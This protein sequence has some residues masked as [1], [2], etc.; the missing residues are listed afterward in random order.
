MTQA[1]LREMGI[2]IVPDFASCT[3]LAS[4]HILR[5]QKFICAL[6][7]AP[8]VL[9]TDFVN[10]CLSQNKRLEPENY[11]LQDT[12]SEKRMGYKLSDSLARAKSNKG[13]LLR[14]Y[15]IYCTENIH[16]GFETYKS[17]VEVNGG[18]CL[19]YRARAGATATLRAGLHEENDG[20][21]AGTSG[22]VYLI[23][24]TTPGEAKLW[25]KFRQMIEGLG[26]NSLVVR[27]D[28]VL[29]LALSQKHQWLDFYNLT[30]KDVKFTA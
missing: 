7:H 27:H 20:S 18:K 6:A 3:H 17:I 19:M 22:H 15:T 23:S 10:D 14:G 24:G 4:P 2:L 8:V 28:W 13:Q 5:T 25:P 12:E 16:G 9:S 21:E 29:D 30:D 26:K 11:L 1:R